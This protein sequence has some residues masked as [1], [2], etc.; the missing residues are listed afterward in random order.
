MKT[1]CPALLSVFLRGVEIN[2]GETMQYC[3]LAIQKGT[4]MAFQAAQKE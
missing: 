3:N 2:P 1:N 4:Q